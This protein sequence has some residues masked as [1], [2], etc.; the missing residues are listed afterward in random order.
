MSEIQGGFASL[1]VYALFHC[2]SYA[3]E[4]LSSALPLALSQPAEILAALL[5]WGAV[6]GG[7]GSFIIITLFGLIKLSSELYRQIKNG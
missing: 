2:I 4:L 6:V 3:V 5:T 1:T 7:G